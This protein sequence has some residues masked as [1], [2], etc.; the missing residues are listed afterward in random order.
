MGP[1]YKN[2]KV[3]VP[4]LGHGGILNV[5]SARKYFTTGDEVCLMPSNTKA[6][7][8]ECHRQ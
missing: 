7:V 3:Y 8:L 6:W 2:D 5:P 4:T 1:A